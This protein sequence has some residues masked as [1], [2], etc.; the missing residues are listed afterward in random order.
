MKSHG[1]DNV[2]R[3]PVDV[4]H[5]VRGDIEKASIIR[6]SQGHTIPIAI[7]ALGGSIATPPK[8]LV[9]DVVEVRSFE[10]LKALGEKAKGK[11]VFFNRPMDP[12]QLQTRDAYKDR[13]SVV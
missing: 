11:I 7:C 13:K 10:E 8:G 2:H 9:A 12:T 4:P 5:W 1:V 6:S 3:E